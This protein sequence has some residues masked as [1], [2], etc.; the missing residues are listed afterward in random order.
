MTSVSLKKYLEIYK[1][2]MFYEKVIHLGT[3]K[4]FICCQ[5]YKHFTL[6]NYDSR[7]APENT[8]YY[9]PRVVIYERKMFIRLATGAW[10]AQ[11]TGLVY[12]I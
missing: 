4:Q 6:V 7:V 11:P 2:W 8:P 1:I 3:S 9:D 10:L 5:S 12:S